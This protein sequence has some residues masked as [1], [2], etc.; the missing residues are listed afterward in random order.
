MRPIHLVVTA[1]ALALAGGGVATWLKVPHPAP[2]R[3]E[4]QANAPLL[5][6]RADAEPA[7]T[8]D[9]QDAA[10]LKQ[11]REHLAHNDRRAAQVEKKLDDL[12]GARETERT[13]VRRAKAK[14]DTP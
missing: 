6:T 14:G 2:A 7:G 5:T 8:R 4:V 10:R 11:F 13:R 12:V 3:P 9:Q 1:I